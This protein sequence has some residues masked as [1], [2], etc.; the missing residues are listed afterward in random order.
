MSTLWLKTGRN[1][2]E[3]LLHVTL[4]KLI[5]RCLRQDI[6]NL[7]L[8]L[9]ECPSMHS[10]EGQPPLFLIP[11][12]S[13]Y[14]KLP[15]LRKTDQKANKDIPWDIIE[16]NGVYVCEIEFTNGG[17]RSVFGVVRSHPSAH[18]DWS[19]A[20][21]AFV[22]LGLEW[23]H[24]SV[25]WKSHKDFKYIVIAQHSHFKEHTQIPKSTL[26]P[27]SIQHRTAAH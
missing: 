18:L 7:F 1:W 22:P 17:N 20:A 14:I 13:V 9:K 5:L 25:F 2:A 27:G 21:L 16:R 19:D 8:C 15:V 23:L 10:S 3:N 11:V 4:W 26:D 6:H 24:L 12:L